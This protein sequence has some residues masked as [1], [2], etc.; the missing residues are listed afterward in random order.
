MVEEIVWLEKG[1]SVGA[2]FAIIGGREVVTFKV[3]WF[4]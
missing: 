1:S 3:V 4:L 2:P